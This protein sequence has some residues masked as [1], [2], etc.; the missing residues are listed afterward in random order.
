MWHRAPNCRPVDG[1]RQAHRRYTVPAIDGARGPGR[2]R[3]TSGLHLRKPP[4][5]QC[6]ALRGV[7]LMIEFLTSLNGLSR[8]SPSEGL[9]VQSTRYTNDNKADL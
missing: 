2:R 1:S 4:S 5:S 7:A 8:D 6:P 9:K 3:R